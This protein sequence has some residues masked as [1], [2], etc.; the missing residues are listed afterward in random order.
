[1]D[2]RRV[3]TL[4]TIITVVFIIGTLG[5][6]VIEGWSFFDALYMT[7][8]TLTTI[9]FGEV[10]ALTYGGKVFTIFL[11]FMGL[12]VVTFSISSLMNYMLNFDL[13]KHRRD[14]MQKKIEDMKN[15]TIVC[16]FGRMGQIVCKQLAKNHTK[17]IVIDNNPEMI[18]KL[19]KTDYLWIEGDASHDESLEA[20]GISRAKVLVSLI[21]DDSDA[22][23]ISLVGRAASK[24]MYIICRANDEKAKTRILKA[25]ANKV[26][27]PT[28]M[29]ALRVSESVLN[30]AVEDFL[31][32]DSEANSEETRVQL[33]DLYVS[34]DSDMINATLN[35]KG[36]EMQDLIVVGVRKPD[37]SFIFK[38]PADYVF[39][40]GDCLITMGSVE[41]YCKAKERLKLETSSLSE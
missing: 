24:D 25:G 23:Y 10:H 33:A 15:H 5:F 11:I 14:K 38:P 36:K 31:D 9:G 37:K 34:K 28:H 29:T 19:E 20:A 2:T 41:S 18:L 12:G 1:M 16:G 30:P 39:C 35:E 7:I 8:I 26:V 32:I 17:F 21:D 4:L 40:E 22:L 13:K 3:F 6:V 27:L